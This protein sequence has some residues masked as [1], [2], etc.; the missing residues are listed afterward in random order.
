MI[1]AGKVV[2]NDR[3]KKDGGHDSPD[4]SKNGKLTII[5]VDQQAHRQSP[6]KEHRNKTKIAAAIQIQRQQ[7]MQD[8]EG[9]AHSQQ[10]AQL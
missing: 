7:Q 2:K 9:K 1:R 8:E 4:V 5:E 10:N 3:F 6:E